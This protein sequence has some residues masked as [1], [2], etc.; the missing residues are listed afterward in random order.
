MD[1]GPK[2]WDE[3]LETIDWDL[4]LG[5]RDVKPEIW[6]LKPRNGEMKPGIMEKVRDPK[7]G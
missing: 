5:M 1:L 6:D 3:E 2:T 7:P 4:K